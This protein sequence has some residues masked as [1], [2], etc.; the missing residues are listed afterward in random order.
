MASN[1]FSLHID[2][3]LTKIAHINFSKGQI[4]LLSLGY[5]ATVPN[6]FTN[7]NEKTAATQ[8]QV[9]SHLIHELNIRQ[10][11]VQITIPD[12]M[13]FS[14]IM[15]MP[16][17]KESELAKSIRLQIDE[18]V[19][20][21]V[22][23][24]NVDFEVIDKLPE[25]RLLILLEAIQKKIATHIAHT[26]E[27]AKLEPV[28]LENDQNVLGR[29]FT[30]ADSFIKDPSI[31]FNFGFSG[32]SI[33]VKNAQTPYFQFTKSMRLGYQSFIRDVKMNFNVE[34]KKAIE[35][36]QKIGLAPNASINVSQVIDP[37]IVQISTELGKT[38]HLMKDRYQMDIKHVYLMN[39]DIY[40]NNLHTV[41][42]NRL[43]VPT[44]SIPLGNMFS[45]NP[46]TQSFRHSLSSFL[47]VIAGHLR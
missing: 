11:T 7:P 36:L 35:I 33:Y 44:M 31:I 37:L 39:Y 41:L 38:I 5:D 14:Q 17:L 8:S 21:P 9:I 4:E 46:I 43:S 2:D 3:Y 1:V 45:P 32:S 24:V 34:D 29:F 42:Q 25:N 18:F 20:I 16:N 10:E 6:F 26:A 12:S 28:S 27:L 22:S 19:P 47:P 40:I 23:E 13:T 15:V 30:E